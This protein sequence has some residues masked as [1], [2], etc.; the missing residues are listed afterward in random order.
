MKQEIAYFIG[1]VLYS[2]LEKWIANNPKIK[3][4]SFIDLILSILKGSKK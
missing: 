1:L 2:M 4:N 3:E